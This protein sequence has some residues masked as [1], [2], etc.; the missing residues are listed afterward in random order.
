MPINIY[1][2]HDTRNKAVFSEFLILD[3]SGFTCGGIY[4]MKSALVDRI[5]KVRILRTYQSCSRTI[6]HAE[7]WTRMQIAICPSKGVRT[8]LDTRSAV[9]RFLLKT[10]NGPDQPTTDCIRKLLSVFVARE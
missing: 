2:K 10:G 1:S 8:F 5:A 9:G 6:N 4:L 7:A 3:L